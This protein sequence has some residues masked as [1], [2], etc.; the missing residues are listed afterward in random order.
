MTVP[1]SPHRPVLFARMWL[2]L[3]LDGSERAGISPLSVERLHRLVYLANAL[4]P[5]YN[6]FVP[7]G[8]ILKYRRGPFFPAV[9]WDIGRLVAQGLV[10]AHNSKPIK[11]ELGYWI[12]ANYG[13]SP[14]GMDVVDEALKVET[15]VSRA[16]YLREIALAFATLDAEQRDS[17][18]LSDV[19][20]ETAVEE[21]AVYVGDDEKNL[22][23][24]AAEAVVEEGAP[25]VRRLRLHRY[26]QYLERAWQ[27]GRERQYGS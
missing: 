15:V 23:P 2:L 4:A 8:Y 7:D 5:V 1:S 25:G 3:L 9:H 21:T 27:L 17:S 19:N 22:A 13:L 24:L 11:D 14:S 16:T 12:S 6:L 20:Y 10:L 18:A 26:F